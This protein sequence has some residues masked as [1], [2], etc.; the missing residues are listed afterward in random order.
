[1][2]LH[3]VITLQLGHLVRLGR[4]L[5]TYAAGARAVYVG[6]DVRSLSL[7]RIHLLVFEDGALQ[8]LPIDVLKA[9][10]ARVVGFLPQV[11]RLTADRQQ[12]NAFRDQ[13]RRTPD[14]FT[15]LLDDRRGALRVCVQR[16][17]T[18][19]DATFPAWWDGIDLATLD[20]TLVGRC[21]VAQLYGGDVYTHLHRVLPPE[22]LDTIGHVLKAGEQH[23]F[24]L[25]DDG[26]HIEYETLTEL[27][28]TE[29]RMRRERVTPPSTDGLA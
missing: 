13:A 15:R 14:L 4:P 2:T 20:M 10:E 27:W 19:L 8:A 24:L 7:E 23:G 29:V 26:E 5:L 6:H 28:R 16:G 3:P 21:V 12:Y 11:R 25:P 9:L 17:A 18:H 22:R 1:M